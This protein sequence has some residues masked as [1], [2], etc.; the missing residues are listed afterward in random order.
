MRF[1]EAVGVGAELLGLE[2]SCFI[3]DA[4]RARRART[5][6]T[7]AR[8]REFRKNAP[9]PCVLRW[10]AFNVRS[11]VP[12]TQKTTRKERTTARAFFAAFFG[13]FFAC[14]LSGWKH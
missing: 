3:F 8:A 13:A 7:S 4:L 14:V 10:C 6:R 1:R 12:E 11:L 9:K 2:R 5:A